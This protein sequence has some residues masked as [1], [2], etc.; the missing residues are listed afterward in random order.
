MEDFAFARALH[1]LAVVLW[2]GGMAFVT[3]VVTP[4][5]RADH[6]PE[7]RMLRFHRFERRFVWHARLWVLVAGAT[8]FWMIWRADLWN[9]ISDPTSWWMAAMVLVWAVF[10]GMLFVIEPLVLHRKMLAGDP[11]GANFRRLAR[12]HHILL[13][14]SVVTILGAVGGSHGLF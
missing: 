7:E 8:G 5:V 13:A 6:P 1:V 11:D 4:A 3:L 10:V 2:I 9:R 14:A 12:M